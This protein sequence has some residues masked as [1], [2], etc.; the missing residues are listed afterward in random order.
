MQTYEAW[1]AEQIRT[2]VSYRQL[3]RT[4]ITASGDTHEVGPANFYRT[5]PGPGE[6]A[7]FFSELFMGSRLRCANCHNHPL[8]SWTQDDYH[9]L[10]NIFAKVDSGKIVRGNP[11]GSNVLYLDGHVEFLKYPG[12]KLPTHE[13][14]ALFSKTYWG[15]CFG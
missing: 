5:T 12:L 9:G 13:A 1:I 14:Y 6:Q 8:D 11:G 10:A 2:K 15:N 3:A 7:E 4:L